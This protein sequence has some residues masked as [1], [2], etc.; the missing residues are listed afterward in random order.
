MRCATSE[1]Y[2]EGVIYYFVEILK[3]S[4]APWWAFL[5]GDQRWMAAYRISY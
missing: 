3:R 4:F 1:L 5:S 2:P